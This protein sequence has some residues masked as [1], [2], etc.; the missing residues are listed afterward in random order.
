MKEHLREHKFSDDEEIV[1]WKTKNTSFCFGETL[2]QMLII[3]RRL[4]KSDK[5]GVHPLCQAAN[6]LNDPRN[7]SG[8]VPY[9]SIVVVRCYHHR[10]L[11]LGHN[12]QIAAN[13]SETKVMCQ[14]I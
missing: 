2:E 6:F 8:L 1:S 4:S 5:Y 11:L 3:C 9:S 7:S 14:K 13:R 12:H 10:G